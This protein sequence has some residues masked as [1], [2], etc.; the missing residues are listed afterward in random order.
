M[1]KKQLYYALGGKK[2]RKA[3]AKA[4]Q[5]FLDTLPYDEG[6]VLRR[7]KLF[8]K[9]GWWNTTKDIFKTS[10]D[11]M[12]KDTNALA[13]ISTATPA[14]FD[15]IQAI[16]NAKT[17]EDVKNQRDNYNRSLLTGISDNDALMQ[18]ASNLSYAGYGDYDPS[19]FGGQDVSE[20]AGNT[21]S[22]A[23]NGVMT[24]KS[25]WG[26]LF[27]LLPAGAGI[28]RNS[29]ANKEVRKANADIPAYNRGLNAQLASVA[30][31]VDMKNDRLA[32]QAMMNDPFFALGGETRTH[33]SDFTNGLTFINEGGSHEENPNEGVQVGTDEE[34]TPNLV[35]EGES[36]WNNDYVFSKRLKVPTE[37]STKYKLGGDMSFADA[38]EKL[39][40][41]SRVRPNDPISN[42]TNNIILAELRD[43]QEQ[44]RGKIQQEAAQ[45]YVEAYNQD[46]LLQ[47]LAG[48]NG[49]MSP[50]EGG[51][52]MQVPQ[53]GQEMLPPGMAFGGNLFVQGGPKGSQKKVV[54]EP[55]GMYAAI[56]IN[57]KKHYYEDED[58]AIEMQNF[59]NNAMASNDT[60]AARAEREAKVAAEKASDAAREKRNQER[61]QREQAT[62]KEATTA[63]LTTTKQESSPIKKN[64][65]QRKQIGTRADGSPRYQYAVMNQY[66]KPQTFYSLDEA[67][68][69][70]DS[71]TFKNANGDWQ[72]SDGKTFKTQNEAFYHQYTELALKNN[73]NNKQPSTRNNSSTATRSTEVTQNFNDKPQG[74]AKT[75]DSPDLPDPKVVAQR[76]AAAEEYKK[77]A[78]D[79]FSQTKY[80]DIASGKTAYTPSKPSSGQAGQGNP[81]WIPYNREINGKDYEAKEDYQNFI[82]YM[83]SIEG[84]KEAQDWINHINEEIAKK[85]S[86]RRIK[87][88]AEWRDLALD[89]KV[90]PVHEYTA[91]AAAEFKQ[92]VDKR[93]AE[94]PKLEAPTNLKEVPTGATAEKTPEIQFPESNYSGDKVTYD[95]PIEEENGLHPATVASGVQSLIDTFTTPDFSN[96]DAVID[97]ARKIGTPI[98]IPV[99]TIGNYRRRNPFDEKYLVNMANANRAAALRSMDNTTGGNQGARLAN[100]LNYFNQRDLGEVA[101]QAYLANRADDAQVAE[102]NRGTDLQNMAAINQR[103]ATQAQLNSHRQQAAFN[104][105]AH[106]YSMRQNIQDRWDQNSGLTQ[107]TFI[108]NLE[109]EDKNREIL[110][111]MNFLNDNIYRTDLYGKSE[112]EN[113][114]QT[115]QPAIVKA[116][117]QSQ[118][119]VKAQPQATTPAVSIY[120]RPGEFNYNEWLEGLQN[121]TIAPEEGIPVSSTRVPKVGETPFADTDDYDTWIKQLQEGVKKFGGKKKSKKRRF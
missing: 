61:R 67:V 73:Q 14:L 2:T 75:T 121:G 27:G 52:E 74:P 105:I 93:K 117:L 89:G 9:G 83:D 3:L 15:G 19:M 92:N 41:E 64:Q 32:L 100:V 60:A 104:G 16:N 18:A 4:E 24:T 44:I 82:K 56:D 101:R 72:T 85:G 12:G 55:D 97:E 113:P 20:I 1:N 68:A 23:V 39:T 116:A 110:R 10:F 21:L 102:F 91:K 48:M 96:A 80:N 87:S 30:E 95:Q 106:G 107:S 7:G 115:V 47:S 76:K 35:E 5:E 17:Y 13:A 45:K 78:G 11:N 6:T 63:R 71:N 38:V 86:K 31:N 50:Q 53:Q 28:F 84:T 62:V 90:G 111:W 114:H 57:G 8:D 54:R 58:E 51:I 81:D 108:Q 119:Q 120:D 59:F 94:S 65:I 69:F 29:R 112:K 79:K 40:R 70:R 36:I 66:G 46:A 33:G 88:F 34:G 22:A 37:I 43:S 99:E 118:P 25:P 109:N 49:M 98:N 77:A 42:A 103:N 26:A